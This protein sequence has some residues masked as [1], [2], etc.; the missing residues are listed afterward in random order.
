ME[1]LDFQ[2]FY[3]KP[4]FLAGPC[5]IESEEKALNVARK[6]KEFQT[7][8]PDAVF[9]FK[10]SFDKANRTS[11]EGFRGP[12]ME[13]GLAI[14]NKVRN[15]FE[16]PVVT[17]VHESWQA[18]EVGKVV[19]IV[20]IPAFLCRQ[21]DLLVEAGKTGKIVNI[22]KGQFLAG[23]DMQYPAGKVAS[24]GNSNIVLTERGTMFGYHNL[25]VDYRNLVDMQELGYPVV[26]DATHSVQQ[27]GG[28]GGKSGGKKVY[29]PYLA[30]AAKGVGVNGYFFE[31]HPDPGN[32]L[33]DGA[34]MLDIEQFSELLPKLIP[35]SQ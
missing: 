29:V 16:L 20:Q 6:V 24:T 13:E 15:E 4:F 10:A 21:T 12:G 31:I 2:A 9:V 27:P 1:R 11:L 34:N 32:A 35:G 14:L 7:H 30:K 22:K 5:V 18:A 8:H 26:F 25:V 28:A 23:S 33:S 17:D 19:D 3:N